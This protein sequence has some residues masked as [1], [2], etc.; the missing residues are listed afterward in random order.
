[1]EAQS[2]RGRQRALLLLG[3]LPATC[4]WSLAQDRP[5]VHTVVIEAVQFSPATLDVRAGDTVTW[6]NR[7]AFPHNVAAGN[8]AFHSGDILAG[9]SWKFKAGSKGVIPYVCTLHPGMKGAIVVK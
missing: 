4:A 6:D 1:M 7:D 5:A 9:R 2:Q 8:N 3:L